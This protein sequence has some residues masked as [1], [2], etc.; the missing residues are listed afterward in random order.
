MV[1]G[2]VLGADTVADTAG[3]G[4]GTKTCGTDK[5]INLLLGKEVP[6]LNHADTTGDT[7]GEGTETTGYNTQCLNVDEGIYRHG[8]TYA[9]A[10][11]DGSCIHDAVAGCVE[12]AVGVITNL[13]NEVTE[14]EHTYQADSRGN[15]DSYDGGNGDG[16]DNLQ[17]ADVLDLQCVGVKFIHLLHVDAQ[18]FL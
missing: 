9:E 14:H 5:R 12:E 8:G 1:F 10:Q 17:D 2:V 18:L 4:N 6:N 13:L 11:E 16:E 15:E 7:E 3:H